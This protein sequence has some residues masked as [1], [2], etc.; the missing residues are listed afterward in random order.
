MTEPKSNQ[1]VISER[2]LGG[3]VLK[4]MADMAS[5]GRNDKQKEWPDVST[6]WGY[7]MWSRLGESTASAHTW[8]GGSFK[9]AKSLLFNKA[10][11]A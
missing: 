7:K 6:S 5:R 2:T 11:L 3:N 9:R 1:Q 10:L 8:T 4:V